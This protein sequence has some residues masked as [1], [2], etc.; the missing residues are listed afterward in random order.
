MVRT[1]L[2][3]EAFFGT[4]LV[5]GHH[6]GVVD[7]Q[8]DARMGGAQLVGG[9]THAFQR[10]EIKLLHG[11]NG[12]GVRC[13]DTGLGI[14]ALAEVADCE[15]DV[16]A[17]VRQHGRGFV[18]DAGVRAGDDDHAPGLTRHIGGGPLGAH[19]NQTG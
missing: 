4:G 12:V 8:V 2:Q 17:P 15:D 9:L 13:G 5:E 11:H 6:A 14:L 16:R 18:A 7:Q 10:R 1:E 19:P 3:L